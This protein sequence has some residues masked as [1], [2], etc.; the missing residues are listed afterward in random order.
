MT[1]DGVLGTAARRSPSR[2][3]P[4]LIRTVLER[5]RAGQRS[6]SSDSTV[7]D[8]SHA[9]SSDG[10]SMQSAKNESRPPST[11]ILYAELV[12]DAPSFPSVDWQPFTPR[13]RDARV[14]Y[15]SIPD[16]LTDSAV[17]PRRG[18]RTRLV[19]GGV[20]RH[21][22]VV[23][24]SVTVV[25]PGVSGVVE[26]RLPVGV[27]RIGPGPD[28]VC[29]RP[30][31]PSLAARPCGIGFPNATPESLVAAYRYRVELAERYCRP[32]MGRAR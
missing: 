16:G 3:V 19:G 20:N 17:H 2:T 23:R 28:I 27:A 6:S 11:V 21:T 18:V 31:R 7:S 22:G 1:D 14:K 24:G 10:S 25:C 8:I 26:G 15:Q 5:V 32:L 30:S 13:G 12:I 9:V 4:S 29:P